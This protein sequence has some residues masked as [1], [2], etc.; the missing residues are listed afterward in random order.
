MTQQGFPSVA[1]LTGEVAELLAA[2]AQQAT[3]EPYAR[4]RWDLARPHNLR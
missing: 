3:A 1:E 4:E 2:H